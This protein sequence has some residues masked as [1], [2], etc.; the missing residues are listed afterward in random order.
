MN[1][2]DGNPMARPTFIQVYE[3]IETFKLKIK[4]QPNVRP[5]GGGRGLGTLKGLA[6]VRDSQERK[7]SQNSIK[8]HPLN[9][10]RDQKNRIQLIDKSSIQPCLTI[11]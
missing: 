10:H 8:S 7:P 4:T 2:W 1:C 9:Y 6:V 3:M 11:Y 5:D